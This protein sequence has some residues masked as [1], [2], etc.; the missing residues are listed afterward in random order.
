MHWHLDVTFN[1]DNNHTL[2]K[3]ALMNLEIIN[4]FC[5]GVL[6]RVKPYCNMSLK[7]IMNILSLDL[8]NNFLEFLAFLALANNNV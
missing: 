3:N 2:D 6:E 4:K 7:R 5:L 1:M 8:E